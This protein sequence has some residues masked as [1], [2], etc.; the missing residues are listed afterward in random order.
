MRE[1]PCTSRPNDA[2]LFRDTSSSSPGTDHYAKDWLSCW[3]WRSSI[4]HGDISCGAVQLVG[5]RRL[6][7]S[8]DQWWVVGTHCSA[9]GP[10]RTHGTRRDEPASQP[11]ERVAQANRQLQA[12][13]RGKSKGLLT[14]TAAGVPLCSRAQREPPLMHVVAVLI[15]LAILGTWTC[16]VW[17]IAVQRT[18]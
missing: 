17:Y 4:A 13:S 3:K 11:P 16:C 10:G 12:V 6:M 1:T 7:D 5:K 2:A 14:Y 15:L 8:Y 9:P 18:V